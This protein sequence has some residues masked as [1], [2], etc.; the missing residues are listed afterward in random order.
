M[1][2][3]DGGPLNQSLAT[4]IN[5]NC[6]NFD[7][8]AFWD[9]GTDKA[10]AEFFGGLKANMIRSFNAFHSQNIGPETLLSLNNHS[11]SLRS[12]K[13]D[14][15]VTDA[16]KNLSLLQGCVT[17]ETLE[18]RAIDTR[19]SLEETENDVFEDIV[20]WL[21]SCIHLR[22]ILLHNFFSGP[23]ILTRLCTSETTKL[24]QLEVRG[25]ILRTATSFHEALSHQ[26]TLES[27]TLRADNED[28][29]RDDVDHLL[30][31]I[32]QLCHLKE[33]DLSETSEEVFTNAD[34]KLIATNLPGLEELFVSGSDIND[35][36]WPSI[37]N[38]HN[39]RS[40]NILAQSSF[41]ANGILNF[42]WQL[43]PTNRGLSLWIGSQMS[44]HDLSEDQKTLI[45]DS[46]SEQVGGKFDFILYREIESEYD[47]FSD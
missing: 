42:I 23:A 12:L 46:I 40:L 24:L 10:L 28:S 5:N 22:A 4:S 34:I 31:S 8:L 20:A 13:L 6:P 37:S 39:L 27:L 21:I 26:P 15:L 38:L 32:S 25:Y 43:K 30:L 3:N 47:S 33:L 19:I 16:I 9:G 41:T 17:I 36:I 14:G 7:E 29:S 2:L 35:T 18:L 44:E 45:R 1:T 11:A